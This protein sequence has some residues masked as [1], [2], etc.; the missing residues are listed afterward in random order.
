[1]RSKH[2]YLL[3]LL[4]IA[5]VRKDMPPLPVTPNQDEAEDCPAA[6]ETMERYQ[7]PGWRGSP[8]ADDVYGTE[9]DVPCDQACREIV[10][11]DI[12]ASLNQQCV[13]MSTSCRM[14]ERCFEEGE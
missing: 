5:C 3:A 4:L 8:G 10:T 1:M 7:C 2:V 13:A 12:S 14:V 6:C 9:D 11:A